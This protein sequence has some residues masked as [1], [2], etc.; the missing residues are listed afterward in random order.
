MFVVPHVGDYVQ[1]LNV[2]EPLERFTNI[3]ADLVGLVASSSTH[4]IKKQSGYDIGMAKRLENIMRAAIGTM[5]QSNTN[6]TLAQLPLLFTQGKYQK[7]PY[8]NFTQWILDNVTQKMHYGVNM[9][10]RNEWAQWNL[11]DR[12]EW[13]QSTYG[14]I[15]D[16]IFDQLALVTLCAQNPTINIRKIVRERK[17]MVVVVPVQYLGSDDVAAIIGNMILSKYYMACMQENREETPIHVI[18]DEAKVF[19]NGPVDRI[20]EMGLEYG[21]PLTLIVQSLN[22]FVRSPQGAYNYA[23]LDAVLTNCRYWLVFNSYIKDAALLSE[24]MFALT[25]KVSR[26]ILEP[27]SYLPAEIERNQSVMAL[28]RL[29]KQHCYA[30]DKIG[31]FPRQSTEYI[32]PWVDIPKVS[33]AEIYAFIAEHQR[34][35][36]GR[37]RESVLNEISDRYDR[38]MALIDREPAKPTSTPPPPPDDEEGTTYL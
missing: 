3:E 11:H 29:E 18:L 6:L 32:T 16:F 25:G 20:L 22:Q 30:F 21:L 34:K 28:S 26:E 8:N 31:Q 1:C 24:Q 35:T 2:I 10:W 38:I 4:H 19:A 37:L 12:K 15:F 13:V 36:G 33:D 23:L 27:N 9:F 17:S 14:Q 7:G 5:V